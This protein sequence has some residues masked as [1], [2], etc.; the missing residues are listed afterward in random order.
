MMSRRRVDDS[1]CV[2]TH[3]GLTRRSCLGIVKHLRS[4]GHQGDYIV[5]C[6]QPERSVIEF[7]MRGTDPGSAASVRCELTNALLQ[8]QGKKYLRA[9]RARAFGGIAR[10]QENVREDSELREP[11][12]FLYKSVFYSSS[13]SPTPR[14]VVRSLGATNIKGAIMCN[15]VSLNAPKFTSTWGKVPCIP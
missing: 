3:F 14:L 4:R 7:G 2:E 5:L 12:M 9:A 6:L 13:T 11:F 8:P 10:G 1:S 15:C